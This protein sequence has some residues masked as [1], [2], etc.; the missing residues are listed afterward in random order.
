MISATLFGLATIFSTQLVDAA[1]ILSIEM[2]NVFGR[3]VLNKIRSF[4]HGYSHLM[5]PRGWN[6]TEHSNSTSLTI[7]MTTTR[8]ATHTDTNTRGTHT[9]GP[10]TKDPN[11]WVDH[12]GTNTR[13]THTGGTHTRG[14]HTRG[15]NNSTITSTVPMETAGSGVSTIL[16]LAE[17][18]IDDTLKSTESISTVYVY[19]TRTLGSL[20]HAQ[21]IP[22]TIGS[23]SETT[24]IASDDD[25]SG[26]ESFATRSMEN[27]ASFISI[28][29][30]TSMASIDA[31]PFMENSPPFSSVAT[32]TFIAD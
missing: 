14:P 8:Y 20:V 2:K 1:P 29:S 30:E 15:H 6:G 28:E 3:D 19:E 4:D 32:P 23:V 10:H 22:T 11:P 27:Q 26:I 13:G 31:T 9:R 12:P 18:S 25:V 16:I 17:P 21:S 7:D 5:G 24:G